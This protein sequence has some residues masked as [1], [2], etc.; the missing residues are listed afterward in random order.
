MIGTVSWFGVTGAN[1]TADCEINDDYDRTEPCPLG[2][3]IIAIVLCVFTFAVA[4]VVSFT[5]L[6]MP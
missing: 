4:V 5:F 1:F 2:G 3:P 6:R